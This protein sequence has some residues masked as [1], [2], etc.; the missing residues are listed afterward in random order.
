MS[1]FG[2]N[3]QAKSTQEFASPDYVKLT[4]GSS[5]GVSSGL[6]NSIQGELSQNIQDLYVIGE[7]SVYFGVG[8]STGSINI[9]RYASCGGLFSDIS[10]GACGFLQSVALKAEGKD[11]CSCGGVS[12]TFTGGI[13]QSVGFQIQAGQTFI[14]ETLSIKVSDFS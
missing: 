2:K 14:T 10:G 1:F 12:G 3:R 13:L 9:G 7:P 6:A 8:P 11:A 4:L 5:N